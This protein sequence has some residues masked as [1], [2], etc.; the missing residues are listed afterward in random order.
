M[1]KFFG[2]LFIALQSQSAFAG[3]VDYAYDAQN[4]LVAVEDQKSASITSTTIYW[5]DVATNRTRANNIAS[6]GAVSIVFRSSENGGHFY[7]VTFMEGYRAGY[8]PEG[9]AFKMYRGGGTGFSQ[10]FRCHSGQDY[11]FSSQ[12]NCEGAVVDGLIGYVSGAQLADSIPLYRFTKPGG[13]DHLVTI[14]YSE[15]TDNG[16]TYEGILGYVPN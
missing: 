6:S 8:S 5:L 15:G 11:F 13:G 9:A 14:Y 3:T 12:S 2:V 10:M 4:R 16:Y 1:L 7:A